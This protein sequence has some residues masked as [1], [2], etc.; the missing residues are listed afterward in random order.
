MRIL[1]TGAGGFVGRHTTNE[2]KAHGHEPIGMDIGKVPP[3]LAPER[4]ITANITD[5]AAVRKAV[6]TLRPD[7]CI[8]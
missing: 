2:L 8:H 3:E 1:I 4:F 5:A 6:E 7:A